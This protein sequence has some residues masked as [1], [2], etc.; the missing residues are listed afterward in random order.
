MPINPE[1]SARFP[2]YVNAIERLG[3]VKGGGASVDVGSPGAAAP[4]APTNA[5]SAKSEPLPPSSPSARPKPLRPSSC[6][7]DVVLVDGRFRV[8]VALKALWHIDAASVVL[9]HDWPPRVGAYGRV[10]EYYDIVDEMDELVV[11]ARKAEVD[12]G[13]AAADL[14]RYV[15]HPARRA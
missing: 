3:K 4:A 11:L 15:N 9:I 13:A 5:S 8:A 14:A 2:D 10:L 7:A 12:W 6:I 1:D